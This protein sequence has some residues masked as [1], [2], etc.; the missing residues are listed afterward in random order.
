MP[1]EFDLL[2]ERLLR[3]GV[4]GA[5]ARRYIAELGDH[6]DDLLTEERQAGRSPAEAHSHAMQRLGDADA[7]AEAMI[8][9]REFRAWSA[10]APAATY[11]VAPPVIL[12]VTTALWMA[13]LVGAVTWLRGHTAWG[14]E[15]WPARIRPVADGAAWFSNTALSVLLGWGLAASAIR[16]RAPLMWPMLGLI[17]LAAVGAVLQVGVTLPVGGAPGEIN[18]G[19]GPGGAPFGLS[20]YWGRFAFNFAA[21]ATPYALVHLL[22]ATYR[23]RSQS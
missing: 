16:A 10:R 14:P 17:V 6:L 21:T 8:A 1:R 22:R 11:L 4:G 9:R 18:L 12:A 7:L 20:G 5:E 15:D 2:R 19:S 13:A 23:P 3:A